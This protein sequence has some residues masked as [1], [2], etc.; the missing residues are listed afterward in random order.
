M[1]DGYSLLPKKNELSLFSRSRF[2]IINKE[3]TFC[4]A[5]DIINK[6]ILGRYWTDLHYITFSN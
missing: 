5:D 3:S 1:F 6:K 2:Y 4:G